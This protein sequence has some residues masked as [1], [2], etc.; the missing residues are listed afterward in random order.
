MAVRRTKRLD[1]GALFDYAV[2]ALG[3]RAHSTGELREKL[4]AKAERVVDV[5]GVISRLKDYGYLNDRK[6]AE[7]VANARLHNHGLG[8]M[9][10]LRELRGRRVASRV[11][12]QAVSAVYEGSDEIALIEDFL[13]R[14]FRRGDLGAQLSDPRRLA[15]VYRRLR[16]AGFGSGNSIQVLKRY[17]S[18][19]GQL[20]GME[21]GE[22]EEPA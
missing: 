13:A 3:S 11:A 19:A 8:R 20:E 17:A 7:T 15:S 5:D 18:E 14:K 1:A 10:V 12:E 9:R 4:R 21:D 16:L 2:R 22:P 6:Y